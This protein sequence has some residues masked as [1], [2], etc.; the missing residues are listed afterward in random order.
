MPNLFL[1]S[2]I[3]CDFASFCKVT[4]YFKSSFVA[5]FKESKVFKCQHIF[6][7]PPISTLLENFHVKILEMKQYFSFCSKV[8][9]SVLTNGGQ[10]GSLADPEI[11]DVTEIGYPIQLSFVSRIFHRNKDDTAGNFHLT[12]PKSDLPELRNGQGR[13]T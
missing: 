6:A 11:K 10:W 2:D 1:V 7:K 9:E 4:L 12:F 3:W 13:K 5:T 8:L